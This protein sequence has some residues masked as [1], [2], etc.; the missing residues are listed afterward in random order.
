MSSSKY[1]SWTLDEIE[2]ELR[3]RGAKSAF[4]CRIY[5]PLSRLKPLEWLC[6]GTEGMK[7]N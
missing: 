2:N 5:L 1:G 3:K 7:L 4:F 6:L